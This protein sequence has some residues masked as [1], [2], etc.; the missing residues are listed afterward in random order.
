MRKSKPIEL[1]LSI[2]DTQCLQNS[3][4]SIFIMA[5]KHKLESCNDSY[6]EKVLYID[7]IIKTLN[8]G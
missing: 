5:L 6:E 2:T 8:S 3:I 4:N 1:E 7:S